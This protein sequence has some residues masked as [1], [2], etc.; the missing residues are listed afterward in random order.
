[1]GNKK[2][3]TR[4]SAVAAMALLNGA[5]QFHEIAEIAYSK[6][7]RTDALYFQY[8]QTA[9]LLLKSYLR[10]HNITRSGHKIGKY[11]QE[12]RDLG[13]AISSDDRFGLGNVV[14]LL[15]SGNEQM[16]FRYFSLKSGGSRP[17][18]SWTREVVGELMQVVAA[19]VE[20][21]STTVPGVAA[22][23]I[24]TFGKP[25]PKESVPATRVPIEAAGQ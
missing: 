5:R 22:K 8:F 7:V 19:F 20:S 15:E 6:S 1:M 21:R 3:R 9:E 23:M 2:Q 17:E 13:L 25:V 14:S 10:V 16:A 24:I 12:C 18:L 11:Y 4:E